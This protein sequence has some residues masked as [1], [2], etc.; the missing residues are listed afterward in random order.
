MNNPRHALVG[1]GLQLEIDYLSPSQEFIAW[2]IWSIY[3]YQILSSKAQIGPPSSS[4]VGR[5]LVGGPYRGAEG[6]GV[7]GGGVPLLAGRGVW[8]RVCA[9]S[10]E[11]FSLFNL[12]MAHFDAYLRYSDVLILKFCFAT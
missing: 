4:G 12:E 5:I 1:E 7:R 2:N 10:P 11:N 6:G 9:P 3:S 8:G